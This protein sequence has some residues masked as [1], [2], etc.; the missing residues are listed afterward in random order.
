MADHAYDAYKVATA[1]ILAVLADL[2]TAY[3]R[4]RIRTELRTHFPGCWTDRRHGDCLAARIRA[5]LTGED[6]P[7]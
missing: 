2:D 7:R 6:P 5:T 4:D 3:P 1:L